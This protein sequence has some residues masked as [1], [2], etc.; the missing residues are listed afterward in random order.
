MAFAELLKKLEN[1]NFVGFEVLTTYF[2]LPVILVIFCS[3]SQLLPP[4][5]VNKLKRHVMKD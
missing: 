2:A 3:G 1:F 5:T 4:M